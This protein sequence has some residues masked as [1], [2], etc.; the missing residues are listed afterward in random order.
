MMSRVQVLAYILLLILI[1]CSRGEKDSRLEAIN[2]RIT[3]NPQLAISMLDSIDKGRL[4][5]RNKHY[6]DLL[7]IKSR[8]NSY[9]KYESDSLILDVIDYY[10]S[11]KDL[12][13]YA[14]SLYYG[15]R[16]YSDLGDYPTALC[17]F[18]DVL[19]LLD[20]NIRDRNGNRIEFRSNVISH[21]TYI[22]LNLRLYNEAKKYLYEL[23]EIDDITEKGVDKISDLNWLIWLYEKTGQTD[24]AIYFSQQALRISD[25]RDAPQFVEVSANLAG[26]YLKAGEIDSARSII[27]DV[28]GVTDSLNR[29]Y[30]LSIASKVYEKANIMDSAYW[31]AKE[32]IYSKSDNNKR[33]GY[34]MLLSK[35]LINKS[36]SDSIVK[37]VKDFS[38]LLDKQYGENESQ[39][40][41]IQTTRYNYRQHEEK[42]EKAE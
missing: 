6:Y 17:Y 5:E 35:S 33:D 9:Q 40:A 21:I 7:R 34:S 12:P 32:I 37:Y 27:R 8:D 29:N 36:P 14:E 11:A 24:S 13:E 15:G 20:E 23:I 1:S 31:C 18:Q 2:C 39:E 22:L 41:L 19:D 26:L 3:D 16:V 4:S 42:L 25:M 30:I 38:S 10:S 28:I